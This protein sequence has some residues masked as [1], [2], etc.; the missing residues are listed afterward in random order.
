M[1]TSFITGLVAST[2][3]TIADTLTGSLPDVFSLFAALLALGI[4]IYY[5][6]KLIQRRK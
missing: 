1:D 5:I 2:T 4:A 6:R 3:E